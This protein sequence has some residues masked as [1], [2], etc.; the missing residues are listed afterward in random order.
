MNFVIGFLLF[1]A[2]LFR[3]NNFE[4]ILVDKVCKYILLEERK[5]DRV[6]FTFPLLSEKIKFPFRTPSALVVDMNNDYIIWGKNINEKRPIASLTK[7]MTSLVLV[8]NNKLED[9]VEIQR[10]PS[11]IE[12]SIVGFSVHEKF[13]VKDLIKGMLIQ[14]GNDSAIA[15]EDFYSSSNF[16]LVSEMNEEARRL[17]L[18]DTFFADDSGLN[19]KNVSSSWDLYLLTKEFLRYDFLKEIVKKDKDTVCSID[20]KHCYELL[21]TNRLIFEGFEGVKT[22]YTQEAGNCLIALKYINS[23]FPTIFIV[24]GAEDGFTRF[25]DV[26]A[27]AEWLE[28]Y[29]QY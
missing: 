11:E 15:L 5:E 25:E 18:K 16:N 14:S 2:S 20:N 8:K 19:S 7:I 29:A 24:L 10:N 13:K 27:S 6:L 9:V 26:R 4:T 12:G 28:Y 23:K 17:G 22:G 21:N 1:F 3:L